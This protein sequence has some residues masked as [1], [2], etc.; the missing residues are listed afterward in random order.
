M[1]AKG[2]KGHKGAANVRE[3]A[4]AQVTEEMKGK[5][6]RTSNRDLAQREEK[7][8]EFVGVLALSGVI[9]TVK[10]G[11]QY[12]TILLHPHGQIIIKSR[13]LIAKGA[14]VFN[15]ESEYVYPLNEEESRYYMGGDAM[16]NLD[17]LSLEQIQEF[18][19]ETVATIKSAKGRK[20]LREIVEEARAGRS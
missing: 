14:Y 11:D 2:S 17:T 13:N 7:K 16:V 8:A 4:P 3:E 9:D 15:P 18:A 10:E 20:S 19:N 5:R 6:G 1:V 12:D